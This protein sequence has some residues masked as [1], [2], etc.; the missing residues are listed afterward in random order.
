MNWIIIVLNWNV[1]LKCLEMKFA[2]FIRRR[3]TQA[4]PKHT[5][6]GMPQKE[7][8]IVAEDR[9]VRVFLLDPLPL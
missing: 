7:L 9:D 1:S 6:Q 8:E 4:A 5:G 3:R 2:H